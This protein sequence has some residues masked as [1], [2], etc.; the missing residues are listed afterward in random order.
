MFNIE[1]LHIPIAGAE[2]S[3]FTSSQATIDIL[4]ERLPAIRNLLLNSTITKPVKMII[5]CAAGLHRIG[6]ITYLLLSLCHFTSD[7]ALLIINRTRAI[8]ARQVGQKRINAAE[9]NLLTKFQ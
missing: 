9:Y 6:T 3:I 4:I 8:T 1:S 5:H 7:Q 2:L